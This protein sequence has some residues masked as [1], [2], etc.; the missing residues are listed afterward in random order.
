MRVLRSVTAQPIGICSRSLKFEM[1][2]LALRM[3]GSW[4]VIAARS[5]AAASTLDLFS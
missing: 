1:F 3:V 2:F 5:L 4:P